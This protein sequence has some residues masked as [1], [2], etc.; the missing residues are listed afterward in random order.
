MG[1]LDEIIF[2][3][4]RELYICIY[5][6]YSLSGVWH[7]DVCSH[8]ME[9]SLVFYFTGKKILLCVVIFICY[10]GLFFLFLGGATSGDA[11]GFLLILYLGIIPG[12]L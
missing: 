2:L 7:M 11:H 6:I 8:S 3:F 1:I 10:L 4:C 12:K 9:F 5:D